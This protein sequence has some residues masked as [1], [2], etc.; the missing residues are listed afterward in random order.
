MKHINPNPTWTQ[1]IPTKDGQYWFYGWT[2]GETDKA[3]S[4]SLIEVMI[5]P[6]G[7]LYVLKGSFW[8]P[9]HE[10]AVGKFTPLI[11]PTPPDLASLKK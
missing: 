10:K 4:W 11:L 6:T 5:T 2:Y 9:K 7:P 8:D 3:P 1:T